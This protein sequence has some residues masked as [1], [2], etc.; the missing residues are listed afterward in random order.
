VVIGQMKLNVGVQVI[1]S[2]V[3]VTSLMM[4][5]QRSGD[6]QNNR[7]YAVGTN[8]VVIGRMKGIV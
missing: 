8:T 7:W 1:S 4:V 3:I 5:V 6:A 2:N